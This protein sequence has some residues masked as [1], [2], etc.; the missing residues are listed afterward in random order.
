MRILPMVMSAQRSKSPAMIFRRYACQAARVP[1]GHRLAMAVT[2]EQLC[3]A[4]PLRVVG[5]PYLEP[6]CF[7]G[8]RQIRSRFALRYDSFEIQFA[9]TLEQ[10]GAEPLYMVRVHE[11]RC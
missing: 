7:L 6:C 1:A 9:G 11:R 10:S 4:Y 5:I 2:F 3:P 8:T